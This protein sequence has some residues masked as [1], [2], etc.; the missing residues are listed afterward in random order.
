MALGVRDGRVAVSEFGEGVGSVLGGGLAPFDC[1][2]VE[3]GLV[4]G[5]ESFFVWV[6]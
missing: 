5:G 6:E 2:V 3:Q 1:A 4:L